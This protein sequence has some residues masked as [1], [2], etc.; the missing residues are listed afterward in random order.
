MGSVAILLNMTGHEQDTARVVAI[1]AIGNIALNLILVTLWG[2]IGAALA[3]A[4]TLSA[5]NILLWLA[6]RRRLNINSMA[7]DLFGKV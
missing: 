5:W 6:V 7:Y 1:S 4:I 3:S 2:L